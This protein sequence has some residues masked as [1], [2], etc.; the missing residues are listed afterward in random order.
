MLADPSLERKVPK[1]SA[2]TAVVVVG[3]LKKPRCVLDLVP[4]LVEPINE[5]V[6]EVEGTKCLPL[7]KFA[8]P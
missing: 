3:S 8:P 1:R 4:L 5:A 6:E 2:G 7:V